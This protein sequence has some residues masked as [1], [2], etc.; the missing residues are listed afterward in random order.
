MP[1]GKSSRRERLDLVMV[2]IVPLPSPSCFI[3]FVDEFRM[4]FEAEAAAFGRGARGDAEG[5]IPASTSARRQPSWPGQG[6]LDLVATRKSYV[7]LRGD[8]LHK[9]VRIGKADIL[10]QPCGPDA[11][12][13]QSGSSPPASV[14]RADRRG[15]GSRPRTD[16]A[17]ADRSSSPSSL[18]SSWRAA[19]HELRRPRGRAASRRRRS[20]KNTSSARLINP[21]PS[22][23]AMP[24][25]ATRASSVSG[26]CSSHGPRRARA[27]LQVP[28]RRAAGM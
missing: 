4:C 3:S 25:S 18:L 14:R 1:S 16:Y 12:R 19:L 13:Y 24:I 11:A 26:T 6:K 20:P 15:V 8:H 22:P 7:S 9:R 23:S 2:V 5:D 10:D 21:R 28:H 17:R 27:E